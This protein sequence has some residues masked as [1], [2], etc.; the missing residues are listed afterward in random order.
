MVA[1][2]R[3]NGSFEGFGLRIWSSLVQGAVDL[4]GCQPLCHFALLGMVHDNSLFAVRA[5][6]SFS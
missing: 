5:V 6:W 1:S 3:G 2:D 4:A